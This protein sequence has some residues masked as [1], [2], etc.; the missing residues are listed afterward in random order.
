MG[1]KRKLGENMNS[2]RA[3]RQLYL[4]L[5]PALAY[6]LVFCYFPMYGLQ[7]AFRDY[8]ASLGIAKSAWVG[9]KH[10]RHF[11][12][13]YSCGRMFR[14]TFLLNFYSLLVG[15]PLPLLLAIMLNQLK[16]RR[17]RR[18]SQAAVIVPH[19]ISTVVVVGIIHLFF[20]PTR[21]IVNAALTQ[22]RPD[23]APVDFLLEPGWF[24]P[25]YIASDVW[26]NAGWNAL[27][28]TAAL[29]SVDPTLYEAASIDGTN[30]WQTIWYID[31]PHL[32]PVA[33]VV[34][35]LNCGT[36]LST[37]VDKALL[38][39]TAGNISTSDLLGVY[40]YNVGIASGGQYS[41]ASSI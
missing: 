31:L 6:F 41:Y 16:N 29:Q 3:N 38:L 8:K 26:Q 7:I 10:F 33:V 14:N 35:I 25:L 18:F 1:S 12:G 37:N 20:S 24:R 15:F 2:L 28:Y 21:G 34:L 40:V 19:F 9:L 32:L 27:I 23:M 17:L 22:L 36:L 11:F 4:L 5:L 39:Q 13:S 30:R